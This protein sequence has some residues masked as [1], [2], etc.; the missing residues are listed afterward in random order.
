MKFPG[1]IEKCR[2]CVLEQFQGSIEITLPAE[3]CIGT[4]TIGDRTMQVYLGRVE[5][6]PIG[7]GELVPITRKR[8]FTLIEV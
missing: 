4:L 7:T 5:S 2:V 6:V 8:K 1:D 3:D